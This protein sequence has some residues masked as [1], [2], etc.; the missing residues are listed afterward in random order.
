MLLDAPPD[1]RPR[2]SRRTRPANVPLPPRPWSVLV[3]VRLRRIRLLDQD[4]RHAPRVLYP[5][6][7]DA[8]H[9]RDALDQWHRPGGHDRGAH[10]PDVVAQEADMSEPALVHRVWGV[11]ASRLVRV[12]DHFE[13]VIIGPDPQ[14]RGL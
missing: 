14:D 12:L 11:I 4:E 10:R 6:G 13:H 7:P 9:R 5:G 1:P 2:R 8:G 3:P